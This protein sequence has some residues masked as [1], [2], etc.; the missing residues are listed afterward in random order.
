MILGL[1]VAANLYWLGRW[2][3]KFVLCQSVQVFSGLSKEG[4]ENHS[5]YPG[6]NSKQ[7]D[8][9]IPIHVNQSPATSI[10][11]AMRL[12]LSGPL[13]DDA[14]HSCFVSNHW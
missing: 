8:C 12:T 14:T 10:Q 3:A 13:I 1:E 6:N 9:P 2:R 5:N 4:A 11:W 7:I